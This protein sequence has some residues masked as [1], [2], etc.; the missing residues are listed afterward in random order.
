MSC[1]LDSLDC[2]GGATW[3]STMDLRSGY[4]QVALDERDK[5]KTTFVT[6][7][8]T[9]V[10]LKRYAVRPLQRASNVSEIN[11]LHHARLELS[12]SYI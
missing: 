8:G 4:H 7:K 6:R 10:R 11:G 5:D 12:A 2:L 1:L 3:F 9:H